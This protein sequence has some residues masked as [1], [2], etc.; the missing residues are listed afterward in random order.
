MTNVDI[1]EPFA[2]ID[3]VGLFEQLELIARERPIGGRESLI[4]LL[5]AT[6][7]WSLLDRQ[8]KEGGSLAEWL[9]SSDDFI[10][11]IELL[12]Q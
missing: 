1:L 7:V 5:M 10:T 2:F 8:R 11:D 4:T 9:I 12:D 6:D 3:I